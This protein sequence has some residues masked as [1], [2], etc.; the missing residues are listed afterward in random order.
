MGSAALDL[1]A[2]GAQHKAKIKD[3]STSLD[4]FF[5]KKNQTPGKSQEQQQP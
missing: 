2:K 1:H 3:W 4:L 5:K